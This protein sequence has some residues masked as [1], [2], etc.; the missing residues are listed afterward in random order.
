MRAAGPLA[1][2]ADLNFQLIMKF[3]E[4]DPKQ[5]KETL[6]QASASGHI[7]LFDRLFSLFYEDESYKGTREELRE[8]GHLP[9]REW[10]LEFCLIYTVFR[11]Q[12]AMIDH[13]AYD[14]GIQLT[15]YPHLLHKAVL[16]GRPGS[17]SHLIE[18]HG[19]PP[20]RIFEGQ[21]A[22][23][24]AVQFGERSAAELLLKYETE[25]GSQQG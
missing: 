23:E 25:M 17:I 4:A 12:N 8:R 13:F 15:R 20:N 18:V 22:R 2:M 14:Y 16:G 3:L 7:L 6:V 5:I 11:G 10:I 9:T 1:A 21:T 24:V 19:F